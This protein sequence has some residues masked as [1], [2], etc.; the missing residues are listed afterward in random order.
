MKLSGPYPKPNSA[1]NV[2]CATVSSNIKSSK[3]TVSGAG[4]KITGMKGTNCAYYT[5]GNPGS[6]GIFTLKVTD[7]NG[8]TSTCTLTVTCNNQGPASGTGKMDYVNNMNEKGSIKAYPNPY[9][10]EINF[11][12]KSPV[13]GMAVLEI[14]DLLGQKLAVAFKGEVKAQAVNTTKYYVPAGNRVQLMYNLTIGEQIF[15]GLLL[16]ER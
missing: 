5:A 3:L 11:Q 16:P 6:T 9:K 1:G 15:H 2:I 13:S 4:W 12:F 8:C 14:Y 10:S 7:N